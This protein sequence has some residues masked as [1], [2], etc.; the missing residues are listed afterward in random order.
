MP[1]N[2]FKYGDMLDKIAM[3]VLHILSPK[4]YLGTNDISRVIVMHGR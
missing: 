1:R 2:L 3:E 4:R